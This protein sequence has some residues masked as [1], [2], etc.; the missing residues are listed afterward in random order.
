MSELE[1]LRWEVR[2]RM[3]NKVRIARSEKEKMI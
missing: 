3:K 1:G 2:D